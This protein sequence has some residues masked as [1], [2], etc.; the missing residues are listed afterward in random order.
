MGEEFG[1]RQAR[2]GKV[3]GEVGYSLYEEVSERTRL[4]VTDNEVWVWVL[5][6]KGHECRVVVPRLGLVPLM[7][8]GAAMHVGQAH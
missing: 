5:V 6:A 3:V 7:V 8:P 4:K 2:Q 1:G